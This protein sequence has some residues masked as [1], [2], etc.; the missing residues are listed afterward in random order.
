VSVF[1][2]PRSPFWHFDFQLH[3][4]RFHGSTKV[5]TKREA[6][7][8]GAAEREKAKAYLAQTHAAKTSLRLDDI[9]GRFWDEKGQ[10]HIGS[11]NTEHRLGLIIEFL[12]KDILLTDIGDDHV[13]R[14]K[15]WRRGHQ[16][17]QGD[18]G[19]LIAPATV[20]HTIATLRELFT[21]AKLVLRVRFDH[22]PH[23]RKHWLKV[24]TE[25]VRELA[26]DEADRLDANMRDDWSP[27]FAFA[28]ASGLRLNECVTLRWTEVQ[29][30]ARQ[31]VKLG[32][33][34]Q[35]VTVWIT[36]TIREILWPL[37]ENHPEMVFTF[38]TRRGEHRPVTY[39]GAQTH[40]RR[41]RLRA[42]IPS[43]ADGFRFHDYRHDLAT[44]ALRETGNLKLVSRMLNHR[45]LRSTL[46]YAHVS[47]SEVADAMERVAKSRTKSRTRLK[48]V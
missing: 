39:A 40:W 17:N 35:R 2:K 19:T 21:Y 5:T 32:K 29:W 11:E 22:E 43:G 12:G 18:N 38:K 15:A 23:W 48:V 1:R 16:K 33:R 34:G 47:D 10:H 41:L 42:S 36:D 44:K 3:G 13:A 27:F 14:L 46:R 24:P 30:P 26:D 37:R 25:R 6:E 45:D 20:N 31:I 8:V 4:R 7:K 28:H 9:A